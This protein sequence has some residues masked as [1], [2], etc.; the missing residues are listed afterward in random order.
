[1]KILSAEEMAS[2]TSS[3]EV[4]QIDET[5]KRMIQEYYERPFNESVRRNFK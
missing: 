4:Y 5:D 2:V 3:R 1:M